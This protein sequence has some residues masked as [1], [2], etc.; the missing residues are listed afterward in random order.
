MLLR[1]LLVMSLL[2]SLVAADAPSLDG[3]EWIRGRAPS[4]ADGLTVVLIANAS[5]PDITNTAAAIGRL[6][7]EQDKLQ[8]ILLSSDG[9]DKLSALQAGLGVEARYPIGRLSAESLAAWIKAARGLPHCVVVGTDGAIAWQGHPAALPAT[10]KR[11][12]P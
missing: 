8:A 11:L 1:V 9:A 7:R 6:Q 10:L 5:T 3:T 12:Q 4:F 2:M